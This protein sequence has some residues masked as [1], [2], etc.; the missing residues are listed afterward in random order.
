MTHLGDIL[1]VNKIDDLIEDGY[2]TRREF[3][4]WSI[5]NY[6]DKVTYERNWTQ[7]TTA[8][9]GLI[10]ESES[11][12]VVARPFSKFF[13]MT[14]PHTIPDLSE[15]TLI[16][17]PKMDGSMGSIFQADDG[18]WVSTR[19]S[20]TSDQ[21]FW[22]TE[23][24]REKYPDWECP[25][26]ITVLV[27]IIYKDNRIVVDYGEFE[28][29]VCIGAR[30]ISTG[31]LIPPEKLHDLWPGSRF[32]EPILMHFD[33]SDLAI[34]NP[35]IAEFVEHLPNDPQFR[36]G[37]VFV[38]YGPDYMVKVK[39]D[40]YLRLHR[41]IY[42]LTKKSIWECLRD[43][44]SY[45]DCIVDGLN[46]EAII[47]IESVG[48]EMWERACKMLSEATVMTADII[49][50]TGEDRKAFAKE[51]MYQQTTNFS[52]LFAMLDDDDRAAHRTIWKDLT[53]G[54]APFAGGMS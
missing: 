51:A 24:L 43:T 45:Q 38:C 49:S 23:W 10:Y 11:L 16:C 17:L 14:E 48:D 40:E 47:W 4:E 29:L 39:K 7:E 8:C 13:N 2:L 20:M 41:L 1:N 22:A 12:K 28:G 15:G 5:L 19:G 37:C 26:D 3:K 18:V 31:E 33:P 27:E 36:E 32:V 35:E 9:R 53:P 21:A 52:L 42:G 6:T 50:R 25:D 44:G 46:E 30:R 34:G 54:H